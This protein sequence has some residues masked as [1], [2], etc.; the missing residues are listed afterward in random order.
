MRKRVEQQK[1]NSMSSSRHYFAYCINI[2]LTTRSR[3][4]SRFKKRT[5]CHSFMALNRAS[6]VSAADW[7]SQTYVKNYRNFSRV[8][9]IRLFSVVEIPS[10]LVY[11]TTEIEFLFLF[12]SAT[13]T[14]PP[15]PCPSK[16]TP[17]MS[18]IALN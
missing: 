5:R 14:S 1:T 9:E 2:L 10:T 18:R 7:L 15:T 11:I 17:V 16:I 13:L 3:H 6:E 8:D 12:C 4:D